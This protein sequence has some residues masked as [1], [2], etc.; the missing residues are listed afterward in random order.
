MVSSK[1]RN[2][3]T[4]KPTLVVD[5]FVF[6]NERMFWGI[7]RTY[8]RDLAHE[9]FA[10]LEERR[11]WRGLWGPARG[12]FRRRGRSEF[13]LKFDGYVGSTKRDGFDSVGVGGRFR[14]RRAVE[15]SGAEFNP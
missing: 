12:H 6:A 11:F 9:G 5:L 7:W 2:V 13:C 15:R 10:L 1:I 3:S 4:Q 14:G 8:G